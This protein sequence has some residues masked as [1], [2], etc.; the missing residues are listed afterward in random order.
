MSV[1]VGKRIRNTIQ[2]GL[3]RVNFSPTSFQIALAFIVGLGGGYFAVLF[4]WMIEKVQI[5]FFHTGGELVVAPKSSVVLWAPAIG[6]LI[7]GP[8]VYFMAREA[9]GHGVPEVMDAV[10]R[11]GGRIRPR[12]VLVKSL[13][14]A[15]CIGSGGSVGREGPIVQT[16]SAIGSAIGQFF[17]LNERQ[18][19][20][21]V[22]CGAGAGIA[23]TYNA[24]IA[25]IFF[26]LEIILGQFNSEAFSLIVVSTVTASVVAHIFLADVPAFT[27]PAYGLVHWSEL[28]WFVFLGVTAAF[29]ARGF[30]LLLYWMEDKWDEMKFMPEYVKPL[31]GGLLLGILAFWLPEVLGVG[32][33]VMDRMLS[34]ES[35][36]GFLLLLFFA[37]TLATVLTLGSGGSG[38]V[39]APSLYIGS[40]FGGVV[41]S[42]A[43]ALFPALTGSPGGYALVGMAAV[44]AG[45]SGAPMTATLTIFELTRDYR[46]ILPLVLAVST[47]TLVYRMIAKD[48]IYTRKLL[49]KGIKVKEGHDVD[50]LR[51]I[52]VGE[53]MTRTVQSVPADWTLDQ[54]IKLMQTERH[55]GFP[56]V[57]HNNHPM[58]MLTL[59]DIRNTPV[60]GRL[61]K[62]VSEVM[63]RPVISLHAEDDLRTAVEYFATYDV[64]RIVVVQHDES[65]SLLGLL[66]RS[67]VLEAY[68]R[69]QVQEGYAE[70]G[71]K[72]LRPKSSAAL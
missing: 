62:R 58:G 22:A 2:R 41:G 18:L 59:S 27:V 6:G 44:F 35:T 49:R 61:E 51:N 9:K 48:T 28:L 11:K 4:R 57:D 54:V 26:A 52:T 5:L 67:D 66:T 47:A 12:V 39:F 69:S 29:V 30:V 7:V 50:V 14:S 42:V 56:V 25:G 65:G 10:I 72:A 60:Q 37:K 8:L 32:Y 53:A 13:A 68:R 23:A 21:L 46:I 43:H 64:G 19:K 63:S 40:I 71:E 17:H 36:I 33:P 20:T 24:P 38:G 16:G 15:F 55:T 1:H 31:A 34:T 45:A 70:N 3:Q